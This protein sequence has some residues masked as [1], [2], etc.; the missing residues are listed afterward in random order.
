[1]GH[2]LEPTPKKIIKCCIHLTTKGEVCVSY[3]HL[4]M[5]N[6]VVQSLMQVAEGT[7]TEMN[8]FFILGVVE[9]DQG[10]KT[11]FFG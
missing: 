5:E 6:D 7:E 9:L 2:T 11:I 8:F 3:N 10:V 1:M 4:G